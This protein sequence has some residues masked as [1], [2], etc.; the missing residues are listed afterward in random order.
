MDLRT[1]LT[2][3]QKTST[4]LQKDTN[5]DSPEASRPS[6]VTMVTQCVGTLIAVKLQLNSSPVFLITAP[7]HKTTLLSSELITQIR[8]CVKEKCGVVFTMS[9]RSLGTRGSRTVGGLGGP[10]Q[11]VGWGG[12]TH[13]KPSQMS[14]GTFDNFLL[15][16]ELQPTRWPE[17]THRVGRNKQLRC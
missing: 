9:P 7:L 3:L 14:T 4:P 13:L 11:W 16:L 1:R 6:A 2:N 8:V 17:Q 12:L 10:E 15:G 5:A